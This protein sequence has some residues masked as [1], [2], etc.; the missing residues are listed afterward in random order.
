MWQGVLGLGKNWMTICL[1]GQIEFVSV[2]DLICVKKRCVGFEHF[3]YN[4]KKKN[5]EE[6]EQRKMWLKLDNHV[7]KVS[8]LC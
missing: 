7:G 4:K 8:Y 3:S 2:V 5:L 6:R 1:V